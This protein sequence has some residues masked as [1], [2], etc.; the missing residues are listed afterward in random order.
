[1]TPLHQDFKCD[2]LLIQPPIRD[3]YLTA[4][5]TIPYG[6]ASIA[7]RMIE[8]GFRVQI[9]DALATAKSRIIELPQTLAYLRSFYGRPDRSPFAL[10]HHFKHF[11]YSFDTI[12]QR[13]RKARPFLV[14]ISSLF[15]AYAGEAFRTAQ[16]VKKIHPDCKIVVGG[17]HATAMP[18]RVMASWAVDFVLR[19]E[20][21]VSMVGLAKA[22]LNGTGYADIPGLV[23]RKPDGGLHV[24]ET[25]SV[26]H[27]DD[28]P[29]PATQLTDRRYYRRNKQAG[30]VV[31]ASRGCPLKCTYC[32]MGASSPLSYRRRSVASVV[33]EIEVMINQY[34]VGF[35]DFEDE[36]LSLDRDWFLRLMD[37]ITQRFAG[38][39]LELRAMN[40]LLP[41]SL[42]EQVVAA[43]Q[44]AGFQTLNLSLGTTAKAQQ[45]RFQRPDVCRAFDRALDLARAYG[46]EAVGYII[47]GAP[48]QK[49]IDSLKDLLYLAGRRVLAGTSVFY[50]SPNSQDYR[51]CAALGLLPH[52]FSGMRSSALPISHST[53][54]KESVTLLRLGRIIN[55]MKSLIDS[56]RPL[57]DP[58]P[59]T[60]YIANSDNRNNAGRQLLQFFLYDGIIRGV[61][62]DGEVFEHEIDLDLCKKFLAGIKT[63]KIRGCKA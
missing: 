26:R 55:F 47:V 33:R 13:V 42:D 21:E 40:G 53:T 46:L 50:P 37:E 17:H 28:L 56:G 4:K 35:I 34:D 52:E 5:R 38:K 23:Y 10:F 41:S 61:G 2:I 24:G 15:S 18:E 54:R 57:P 29:L 60:D 45:K 1:M 12:G 31:V 20:G 48:F 51:L 27:L 25:A 6:L 32:S 11:G 7:A 19:G 14:G 30:A 59:A 43:M 8:A 49:A 22:L 36:N 63:V 62:P 3:F 39:Q 16:I 9:L 58:A 44:A